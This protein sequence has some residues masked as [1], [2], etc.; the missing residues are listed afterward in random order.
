MRWEPKQQQ[1]SVLMGNIIC[2][3]DRS[4]G[5]QTVVLLMCI[6]YLRKSM[7]ISLRHLLSK[8]E[9]KDLLRD[10]KNTKWGSRVHRLF[11]YISRIAEFLLKMCLAKLARDIRLL[12]TYSTLED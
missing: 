7:E 4:A 12:L 6:Q 11:N 8:E 10:R 5:S 2:S 3:T 1:N 9:P